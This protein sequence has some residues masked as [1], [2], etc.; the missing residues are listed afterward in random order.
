MNEEQIAQKAI[1]CLEA[2]APFSAIRLGDGEGRVL[3][4]PEGISRANLNKHLHFWFGY[5]NILNR[6]LRKWKQ[7]L[8][9]AAENAD[10]LGLYRGKDRNRFWQAPAQLVR[11]KRG[12][13]KCENRLHR[14]LADSGLLT[15]IVQAAESV[16][17]VTCRDVP[18]DENTQVIWL[19]EEAH[20]GGRNDHPARFPEICTAVQKLAGP[21]VLFLI[22]GG[23]FGK[24]YCNV[25]R[26]K[27]AVAIDIGSVFDA[28]AGIPSRSYLQNLPIRDT[29]TET[30]A[31]V[32]QFVVAGEQ[33][34]LADAD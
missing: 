12:A 18:R 8:V 10:A 2:G 14:D 22:G 21:G 25:V 24:I 3:L 31:S 16:V 30:N 5:S 4:W 19:P 6:S 11:A 34:L 28:L 17:F 13:I 26:E 20:T 27:G 29:M 23:L 7:M 33:D 15:E 32:K 1:K 9:R